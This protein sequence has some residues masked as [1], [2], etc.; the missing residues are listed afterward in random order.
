VQPLAA[1][2]HS[3]W[4]P[5]EAPQGKK[6][7]ESAPGVRCAEALRAHFARSREELAGLFPEPAAVPAVRKEIDRDLLALPREHQGKTN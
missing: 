3:S 4:G 1:L 6:F 7:C 2:E 5:D